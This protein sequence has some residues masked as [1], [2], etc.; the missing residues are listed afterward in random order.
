MVPASRKGLLLALAL[1]LAGLI[2][3]LLFLGV[4]DD[5]SDDRPLGL[6][7]WVVA[8]VLIGPGFGYLIKWKQMQ[9]R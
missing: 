6:L 1:I 4:T 3:F 9:G 5:G 8:G 7:D 2:F